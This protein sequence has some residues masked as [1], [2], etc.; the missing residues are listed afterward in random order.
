MEDALLLQALAQDDLRGN[1]GQGVAGG[2][3]QEGNGA[4][5][6]GVDLDDVQSCRSCPQ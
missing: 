3:G 6:A 2:L 1:V 5:G 4:G